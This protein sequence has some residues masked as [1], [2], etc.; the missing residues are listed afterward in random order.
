MHNTFVVILHTE[1]G[2]GACIVLVKVVL[3]PWSMTKR[4]QYIFIRREKVWTYGYCWQCSAELLAL[5]ADF[6]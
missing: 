6:R 3:C 5:L 2:D 1:I 4:I